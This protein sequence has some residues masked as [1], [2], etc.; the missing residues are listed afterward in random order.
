MIQENTDTKNMDS[1]FGEKAPTG[2]IST[3]GNLMTSKPS[4]TQD[5]SR[6]AGAGSIK[7]ERHEERKRGTRIKTNRFIT[8]IDTVYIRDL[9]GGMYR[10]RSLDIVTL[11]RIGHLIT[12]QLTW[13][14]KHNRDLPT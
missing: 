6:G 5:L 7:Y 9:S 12:E 13:L 11:K 2:I 10:V 14:S 4:G 3:R 8:D 1:L